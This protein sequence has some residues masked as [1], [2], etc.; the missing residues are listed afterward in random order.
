MD[1]D[2]SSPGHDGAV[3]IK[4]GRIE[5]FAAHLPIS[6]NHKVIAGRGTRHSAALGLAECSDALAV[7][8][9]E[10]RG[11]VSVAEAGRLVAVDSPAALKQRLESFFSDRFPARQ[12]SELRQTDHPPQRM[13]KAAGRRADGG[14]LVRAGVQPEHHPMHLH[15][16][17]RIPQPVPRADLGR[18]TMVF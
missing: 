13:A 6:K 5:R 12:S 8:V 9:S 7:V 11:T 14:C 1:I 18:A 16:P 10:E 17:V 2:S 4:R 15:R 3:L